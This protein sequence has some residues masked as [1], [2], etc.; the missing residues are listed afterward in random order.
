MF[1]NEFLFDRTVVTVMDETGQC[2]DV[3]IVFGDDGVYIEQYPT[4]AQD[5]EII[6]Q[7]ESIDEGLDLEVEIEIEDIPDTLFL[8]HEQF[9][10]IIL[11]VQL[12]EGTY[13]TT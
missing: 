8:T 3:R 6:K 9:R 10:N 4:I 12:P 11:A 2:G 7:A 1:T 13:R 5:A